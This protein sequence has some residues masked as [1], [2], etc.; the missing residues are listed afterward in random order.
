MAIIGL[1]FQPSLDGFPA[2][3]HV[4]AHPIADRA[5]A[6]YRSGTR[7]ERDASPFQLA[8]APLDHEVSIGRPARPRGE[9]K[10]GGQ[11]GGG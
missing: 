5:V 2:L 4:T 10:T 1:P 9:G 7:C 3:P 8:A 6:L 11:L